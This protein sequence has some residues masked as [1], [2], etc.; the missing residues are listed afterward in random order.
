MIR[1]LVSFSKKIQDVSCI[2]IM[3]YMVMCALPP[4]SHLSS[5][6]EQVNVVGVCYIFLSIFIKGNTHL[7]LLDPSHLVLMFGAHKTF[8]VLYL[9]KHLPYM[10]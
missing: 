8:V 9:G 7:E 10:S 2:D 1:V 3:L 6:L 4:D 5:F